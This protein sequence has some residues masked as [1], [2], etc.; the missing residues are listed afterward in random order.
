MRLTTRIKE[1]NIGGSAM[2]R[3][4]LD[5][6][7]A[8]P[9]CTDQ[10]GLNAYE[11]A[12]EEWKLLNAASIVAM[13]KRALESAASYACERQAFGRAIGSFQGLAHPLADC[14]AELDGASLLIRRTVEAIGDDRAEAGAM[15]SMCVWWAGEVGPRAAAK[16]MRVFV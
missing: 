15:I 11:A 8:E 14:S 4:R 3:I 16:A 10:E 2:A 5:P 13:G 9:L 6:K 12:C 1:S 7:S